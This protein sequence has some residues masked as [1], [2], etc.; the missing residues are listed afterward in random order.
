M[1]QTAQAAQ[2][3]Q[4]QMLQQFWQAQI[5]AIE[6]EAADFK[7]FALPLARI[8][9]VMKSDEDVKV[10]LFFGQGP[11]SIPVSYFQLKM[12][13][14][15]V[16]FSPA[17]GAFRL[18]LTKAQVPILF[19]KAC[20]IFIQE[21]SFRA[22]IHTEENKRRTLQRSDIAMAITK[23]DTFDFLIDIVPRED[24]KAFRRLEVLL[25]WIY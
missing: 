5:Q 15:E 7:T 20:E 18:F 2:H 23:C 19:A 17:V 22:W 21:L 12:I 9:K 10:I 16:R 13:S 6:T 25:F 11:I 3:Q 24:S 4:M 14:A 8:K 1:D